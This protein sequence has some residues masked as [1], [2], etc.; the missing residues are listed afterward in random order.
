MQ[1]TT[2]IIAGV[3]YKA[4]VSGNKL[5]LS[6]GYSHP[7]EVVAP[8]GIK[9]ETKDANTILAAYDTEPDYSNR[10]RWSRY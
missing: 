4:A 5:N 2:L 7:V 9:F 10:S 8:E 1:L 6:L 3:G